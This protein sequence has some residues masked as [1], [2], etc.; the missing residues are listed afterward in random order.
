MVK[1]QTIHGPELEQK[2]AKLLS[3]ATGTKPAESTG[4]SQKSVPPSVFLEIG[5]FALDHDFVEV[6]KDC[7]SAVSLESIQNEPSLVLHYE[8]IKSQIQVQGVV[9]SSGNV[10]TKSAVNA[11]VKN[12]QRLEEVVTSASRLKDSNTLEVCWQ[13]ICSS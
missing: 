11:R 7:L 1:Q 9:K 13:K 6:A 3:R 10:F 4:K 5:S 12:L 2:I 8:I